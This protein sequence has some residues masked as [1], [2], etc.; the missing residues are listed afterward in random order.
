MGGIGDFLFGD[1]G[2]TSTFNPYAPPS[3]EETKL[4]K[5]LFGIT[6]GLVSGVNIPGAYS[7]VYSKFAA[8]N[9]GT[10]EI[11]GLE[12]ANKLTSQEMSAKMGT[13]LNNLKNKG[14]INSTVGQN[15]IAGINKAGADAMAKNYLQ[16]AG[17]YADTLGKQLGVADTARQSIQSYYNDLWKQRAG[18]PQTIV[19]DQGSPGL[20]GG[21]VGGLGSGLGAGLAKKWF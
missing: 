6:S 15:T 17:M 20:L 9:N 13:T 1:S 2:G 5:D 12:Q 3:A 21:I 16:Y 7:D 4:G 11:P 18:M 19:Q 8:L 14:V 10:A